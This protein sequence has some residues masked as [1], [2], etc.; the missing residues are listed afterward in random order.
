LATNE[1]PRLNDT[2]RWVQTGTGPATQEPFGLCQKVDLASIGATDVLERTW[3]ARGGNLAAQEVVDFA[4][5]QTA[6]RARKVLESWRAGCRATIDAKRVT[7]GP[8]LPVTVA[9]GTG[10]HYLVAIPR[11]GGG[12]FHAFGMAV[13]GNRMTVLQMVHPGQDHDYEP[14]QDPMERAVS[15]AGTKLGSP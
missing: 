4:D 13:V 2:L 8:L 15:L 6:A 9:S 1:L 11:A 12:T 7:V 5:A 10:W 3:K 14:G